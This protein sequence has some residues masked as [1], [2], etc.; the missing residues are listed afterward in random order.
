MNT[1]HYCG[2]PDR[3][4]PHCGLITCRNECPR[5]HR[6]WPVGDKTANGTDNKEVRHVLKEIEAHFKECAVACRRSAGARLGEGNTGG[7]AVLMAGQE[8]F[9]HAAVFVQTYVKRQEGE[10]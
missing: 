8:A 4:C 6:P 9:E 10:T 3:P 1:C 2:Q 7:Y 5:C